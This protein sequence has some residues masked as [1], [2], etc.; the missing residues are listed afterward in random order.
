MFHLIISTCQH[1]M[2]LISARFI[3]ASIPV[4]FLFALSLFS[5]LLHKYE[6]YTYLITRAEMYT[7]D[8]AKDKIFLQ[9]SQK[10]THL[11]ANE[12]RDPLLPPRVS[13][14]FFSFLTRILR[15]VCVTG[16]TG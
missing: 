7:Y 8:A 11:A 5:D 4:S 15:V 2:N 12:C 10:S 13:M 1:Y 16:P 3:P 9:V 6:I 14:R